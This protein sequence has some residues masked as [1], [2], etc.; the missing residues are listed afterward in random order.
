MPCLLPSMLCLLPSY[1]SSSP[2]L[3]FVFSPPMPC[4]LPSNASP[5]PLPCF[6]S[7]PPMLRLLPSYASLAPSFKLSVLV[8]KSMPSVKHF[9]PLEGLV[10]SPRRIGFFPSKEFRP[11]CFT[12]TQATANA[13]PDGSTGMNSGVADQR[14]MGGGLRESAASSSHQRTRR[15]GGRGLRQVYGNPPY[16]PRINALKEVVD[17]DNGWF[18]EIR[19]IILASTPGA[20]SHPRDSPPVCAMPAPKSRD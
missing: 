4:L 13:N 17:V 10:T 12:T 3:C 2:L 15:G 5:S 20:R 11:K 8:V 6:A 1:A 18:M 7:S 19:C 9:L 14:T 16:H